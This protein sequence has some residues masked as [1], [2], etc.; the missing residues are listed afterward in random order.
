MVTD[1][2]WL[3]LTRTMPSTS[4][5]SARLASR[6]SAA[7]SR[8]CSRISFAAAITARPL[9]NVVCEPLAPPS[10]GPASVSWYRIRN[11][12]GRIPRTSAARIGRAMTEPVPH[13]WAPVTIVPLPSALIVRCAP[14]GTR[15][16]RP[17]AGRD[18]DRLAV[19]ERSVPVDRRRRVLQRL[20]DAD[21]LEDL[22][23]RSLV[24]LVDEVAATELDGV[25]AEPLGDDVVVLLERPAGRRA[26]RARGR[27][28]TAAC[29][30]R[31]R[32]PRRRR[33]GSGTARPR[34][35]RPSGRGTAR[36]CC[37]RRCR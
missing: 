29:S 16:R 1:E 25:E 5:R 2:V 30:C 7:R 8:S 11:S 21:P 36:P 13:S 34:T 15:E 6:K 4:S 12:S 14:D 32:R 37:R 18:P 26:G 19:L 31:R 27:S 10:Y 22:A 33:S 24:A 23:G 9:L 35:S 20:D 3:P 28:R 17:P